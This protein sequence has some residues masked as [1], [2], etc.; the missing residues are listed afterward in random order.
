MTDNYH[1]PPV[2]GFPAEA[3]DIRAP[4]GELD[5]AIGERASEIADLEIKPINNLLVNG[6]FLVAQRGVNFTSATTFPNNDDA[7]LIDQYILLSDG[8]DIVDVSRNELSDDENPYYKRMLVATANKK[9]GFLNVLRREKSPQEGQAVSFSIRVRTTVA[10]I[11]NIRVGIVSWNG[12]A[13]SITSDLVSAWNVEGTDPTLVSNWAYENTPSDLAITTDWQTFKIEN[14]SIDTSGVKNVGVF[15]WVDDTDAALNDVLDIEWVKLE[16]GDKATDYHPATFTTELYE[17]MIDFEHSYGLA[18]YPGDNLG[19]SYLFGGSIV[20]ANDGSAGGVST[21][22]IPFRVPKK[23][24][25]TLQYWDTSGNLSKITVETT[26]NV[27]LSA[28]NITVD[29]NGIRCD[30]IPA[31]SGLRRAFCWAVSNEL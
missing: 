7:Y 8:N 31:T 5:E 28:G 15:V 6:G 17:C 4:L 27:G 21:F 26:T 29:A 14:V 23:A 10:A 30:F 20:D 12:T 25:P 2:D 11:E 18:N 13:D 24:S 9:F 16:L 19:S 3:A 1:T 22:K